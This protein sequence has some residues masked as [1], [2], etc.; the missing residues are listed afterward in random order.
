MA[1]YIY[2]RGRNIMNKNKLET[3]TNLV[4]GKEI[5]TIWDSEKEE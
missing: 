1:N 3:L 5:R 2:R 4:E